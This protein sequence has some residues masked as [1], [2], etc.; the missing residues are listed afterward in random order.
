MF[1]FAAE[2]IEI[3]PLKKS[4]ED[5]RAGAVV[6]FE[7]IVRN[8]NEGKA[9]VALEYEAY[10]TLGTTEAEKILAE[11]RTNF[12][13]LNAVC[14]HRV[15]ELKVGDMAVFVAVTSAHRHEAYQASR[16]I[17]DEIK[18]RLPIWKKETYASGSSSWVNCQHLNDSAACQS[19]ASHGRK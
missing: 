7:G 3:E 10:E 1:K 14:V 15:G 16:Y 4:L 8:H 11:A 13:I 5:D 18:T 2:K 12:G 6:C 17:I 9:V 19:E